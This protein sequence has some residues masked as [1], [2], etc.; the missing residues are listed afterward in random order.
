MIRAATFEDHE[1]IWQIIEPVFRAGATYTIPRD[2]NRQDAL[3]Y[4][5]APGHEVFVF[6]EDGQ[7]LGTYFIQANQRG[8]GAHV[9]N[10]GYITA[11]HAAGRGI[12]RAMC[13]HSLD[14]ARARG[15]LAMQ[16]NFVVSTNERA[17][18]LWHSLGF[19]IVGRLPR[20]FLH[21]AAGYVDAL[22][23]FRQ[24]HEP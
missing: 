17:V 4:W 15:F 14:L 3:G 16:F 10:C 13:E 6:D 23:M 20:A 7:I 11:A 12:A 2:I 18:K 22:V 9:A 8:A 1:A 24:L 21:P 5:F 19:E